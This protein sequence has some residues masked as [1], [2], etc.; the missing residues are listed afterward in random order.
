MEFDGTD[1]KDKAETEKKGIRGPTAEGLLR[2]GEC[3]H[4]F[5]GMDWGRPGREIKINFVGKQ[6]S[7]GKKVG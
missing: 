4:H 7:R 2:E 5:F 6:Q 1:K 3:N